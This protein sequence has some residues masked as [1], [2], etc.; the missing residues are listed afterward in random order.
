[1][2]ILSIVSTL[3][4]K[5]NLPT[6]GVFL[7]STQPTDRQLQALLVELLDDLTTRNF[8]VARRRA[9]GVSIAGTDQGTFAARF[10]VP[11]DEIIPGTLWDNTARR[12][13]IGP[14]TDQEWQLTQANPASGPSFFYKVLEGRFLVWPAMSAGLQLSCLVQF[15]ELVTD[16]TGAVRR[17]YPTDDADLF[18]VPDRVIR[19]G[20]EYLWLKLKSQPYETCQ[21]EYERYVA[22]EQLSQDSMPVLNLA[23]AEQT[24]RPGI[25]VPAGNWN[26]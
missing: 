10:G 24:I 25:W 26:V 21:Q 11:Y 9:T 23:P 12:P 6:L 2:S 4:N 15:W 7:T 14:Q 16:S 13:L 19:T 5:Y 18:I 22:E 3:K 20:L 1:M 17:R 8:R